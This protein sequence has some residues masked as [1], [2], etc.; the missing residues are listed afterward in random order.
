MPGRVAGKV[1]IVSG[2]A[3]GMGAAEAAMLAREGA[4]VCIMDVREDLAA[5]VVERIRDAGGEVIF[6]QGDV[7]SEDD[8][9]RVIAETVEAF[10]KLTILVNNAGIGARLYDPESVEDWHHVMD[11]NMTSVFIGTKLAVK[12]MIKAGGGAIVN[13]A[14]IASFIAEG[15][16]PVYGASKSAVWNY[17]KQAAVLYAKNNIRVNSVHPGFMP[18]M[19]QRNNEV[20]DPSEIAFAEKLKWVPMGRIGTVD[21]IAYGVLF[22]ASDEAS[23]ITGTELMID[24]GFTAM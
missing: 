23:Y 15:G 13:I 20:V 5:P 11:V 7:T 19:I 22:L 8:W 1:A 21:E 3:N 18:R 24:G 6:V 9:K 4:K 10:G 12:E 17:T 14:S 16:N 2:G